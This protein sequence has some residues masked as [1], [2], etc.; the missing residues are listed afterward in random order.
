MRDAFAVLFFVSVGMLFDPGHVLRAPGLTA[1]A[2]GIVMLGKPLAAMAIVMPMGYG[3][4][5]A[6]RVAVALAQVGEFSFMLTVL[7]DQLGILSDGA[8]DAVVAAAIVSIT[9][10]PLLYRS[11]P[12]LERRLAVTRWG[13]LLQPRG[14]KALAGTGGAAAEEDSRPGAIVVGYGP[15]GETVTRL[16]S[17]HDILPTVIELNIDTVRRLRRSGISAVYGDASQRNVLAQAGAEKAMALI[18]STPGAEETAEAIKAARA[19]NPGIQVLARSTFLS[20]S[21]PMSMAGA[22]QVFAA[23]AEVAMAMADAILSR[24]GATPEQMD[25]ERERARASL[26]VR[27]EAAR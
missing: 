5:I 17:G 12:G 9:L 2:I 21:G 19:M 26:Y 6:L 16:L 23:E 8:T 14:G 18:I 22:D 13:R 15:V 4:K 24:L 11:L 27:G 10:N 3:L 20:Q 7:G 25:R 1:A